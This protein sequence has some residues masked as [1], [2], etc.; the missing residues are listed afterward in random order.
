MLVFTSVDTIPSQKPQRVPVFP[1][2]VSKW[3]DG[4]H[5]V[6]F[7]FVESGAAVILSRPRNRRTR[8]IFAKSVLDSAFNR[9]GSSAA[10]SFHTCDLPLLLKR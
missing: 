1:P 6:V 9:D 5:Q 8:K 4:S 7:H 3:D 10:P 2:F